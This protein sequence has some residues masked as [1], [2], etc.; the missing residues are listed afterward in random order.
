MRMYDLKLI[1]VERANDLPTVGKGVV[2]VANIGDSYHARI[3]NRAG[4][5]VLDKG[6][7]EFIPDEML[8]QQLKVAFSEQAIHYQT[9]S[10]LIPKITSS[11]DHTLTPELF[12]CY[13]RVDTPIVN[14]LMA[15]LKDEF[16]VWSDRSVKPGQDIWDEQLTSIENCDAMLFLLTSAS[17]ANELTQRQLNYAYQINCPIVPIVTNRPQGSG[18]DTTSDQ[19]IEP[20]AVKDLQKLYHKDNLLANEIRESLTAFKAD[21]ESTNRYRRLH[22]SRPDRPGDENTDALFSLAEQAARGLEFDRAIRLFKQL[23]NN[24]D[25][26]TFCDDWQGVLASYKRVY[27]SDRQRRLFEG[28]YTGP[29]TSLTFRRWQEYLDNYPKNMPLFDPAGYAARAE[30]WGKVSEDDATSGACQQVLRIQQ[31]E[32]LR[33][34]EVG[35]LPEPFSWIIV[36]EQRIE[37][38]GPMRL[39]NNERVKPSYAIAKYPITVSQFARFLEDKAGYDVAGWWAFNQEASFWRVRQDAPQTLDHMHPEHPRTFVTW[40]EAMAFCSWLSDQTGK[41]ITLPTVEQWEYAANKGNEFT[42]PWGEKW[43]CNCCNNSVSPSESTGISQVTRYDGV[44]E[45]PFGVSDMV[46][47]VWEWCLDKAYKVGNQAATT[48]SLRGCSSNSA[49]ST[50]YAIST[51]HS[52]PAADALPNVGFRIVMYSS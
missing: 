7:G 39:L 29:T 28:D 42:Y 48:Y 34:S 5:Q 36:P 26:R 18:A 31:T 32:P 49:D 13:S 24:R 47:N 9:K 51:Q 44:G 1:S 43:D 50:M 21:N 15:E 46:G 8:G 41:H 16:L 27:N 22:L 14:K 2:I 35:V 10:E 37:R 4:N 11:L 3:F 6:N 12:L 33:M 25:L 17:L 23:S 20:Q 45:S 52:L 38:R 40:Y 19:L 30:A